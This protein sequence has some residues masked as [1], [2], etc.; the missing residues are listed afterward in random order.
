MKEGVGVKSRSGII[1]AGK[2]CIRELRRGHR[3]RLVSWAY[4]FGP[5]MIC[6]ST[7]LPFSTRKWP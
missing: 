3:K 1:A 7:C 2:I 6:T 5:L 4:P